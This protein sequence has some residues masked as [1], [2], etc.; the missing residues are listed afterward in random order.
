MRPPI[1]VLI[2]DDER[3]ARR[4]IRALLEAHPDMQ[5]VG[6]A[7]SGR[8]AVA[9][10]AAQN[11]ALVFLDVQMPDGNGFDVV[12]RVGVERMPV[13]IFATAYD[14][15]AL[16]AFDAHAADYLLKP[17]D[18]ARF[19]AALD[20]ARARIRHTQADERL[21]RLLAA[22][23][24]RKAWKQRFTVKVGSRMQFI[25]T[26]HIDYFEAEANYVRI[27]AAGRTY[28]IRESLGALAGQ[29]DPA[30]FLR[31]HRSYIVNLA[32]V[33]EVESLYAGEFILYLTTGRKL[34]S[35][36]S[37]RAAIQKALAL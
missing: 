26:L 28:L 5:V 34:T 7:A 12:R 37:F 1:G 33:Q 35:G 32:R 14:E 10:I 8:E 9:A 15:Y 22:L 31:I 20:H 29:L 21:A 23:D 24:D 16:E 19:D 17:I 13:V 6:E 11:P 4:G 25:P 2:V 36:R 30:K 18:R 3:P 27:H